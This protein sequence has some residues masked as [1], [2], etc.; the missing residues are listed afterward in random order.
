MIVYGGMIIY[1]DSAPDGHLC[2]A[3]G[4]KRPEGVT[5]LVAIYGA[6]AI[7]GTRVQRNGRRA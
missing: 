7:Y 2:G 5:C 4:E 1:W 3:P 6:M